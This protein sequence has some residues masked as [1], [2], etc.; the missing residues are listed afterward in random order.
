MA[1]GK[2]FSIYKHGFSN[3]HPWSKNLQCNAY[4][5][6]GKAALKCPAYKKR[7][8][9]LENIVNCISSMD[10]YQR[11][12]DVSTLDSDRPAFMRR[13]AFKVKSSR[14]NFNEK[15]NRWYERLEAAPVEAKKERYTSCVKFYYHLETL[16]GYGKNL[17]SYFCSS[18]VSE[19]FDLTALEPVH[20][21]TYMPSRSMELVPSMHRSQG[22]PRIT[23]PNYYD[24]YTNSKTMEFVMGRSVDRMARKSKFSMFEFRGEIP[25]IPNKKKR[26]SLPAI[27]TG[28]NEDSAGTLFISLFNFRLPHFRLVFVS[29]LFFVHRDFAPDARRKCLVEIFLHLLSLWS[30]N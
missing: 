5:S 21:S 14:P 24:D 26:A 10:K 18:G 13:N 4:M 27:T 30:P 16:H 29:W 11:V 6:N 23:L 15:K 8:A 2:P 19:S 1:S 12:F 25:E 20:C 22:T 28:N 17:V 7:R 9:R 3:P